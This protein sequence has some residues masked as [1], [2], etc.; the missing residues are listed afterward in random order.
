MMN[1][2]REL[3]P[4]RHTASRSNDGA[5]VQSHCMGRRLQWSSAFALAWL[6][7]SPACAKDEQ[8]PA[9]ASTAGTTSLLGTTVVTIRGG[10]ASWAGSRGLGGSG[11]VAGNPVEGPA[12][13][14]GLVNQPN[15]HCDDGNRVSGDGCTSECRL[16]ADHLC[17]VPG[18]PCTSTKVC[19]DGVL[20]GDESCDD[21]GTVEGDGCSATCVLEAGYQC[22]LPGAPCVEVCGDSKVV[23]RESC[24]DGGTE[25]GDGCSNGCQVEQDAATD[26][27]G[28]PSYWYCPTPGTPCVR[29]TCGNGLREGAERC[30]DG[31]G[32]PADGCSP[33]CQVEPQCT[34]V[35]C[36]SKCG[37]GIILPGES[38]E[39]DDGNA[40]DGDGCSIGCHVESGYHC[41]AV[42]GELPDRLFIPIVY[43]DFV[44]A[45]RAL[46]NA[47]VHPDFDSTRGAANGTKGLVQGTLNSV[48]VPVLT[49]FCVGVPVNGLLTGATDPACPTGTITDSSSTYGFNQMSGAAAFAQWYSDAPE[50]NRTIVSRLCLKRQ[51]ATNTYAFDS[52]AENAADC[53]AA[54]TCAEGQCWFLPINTQGFVAEG[55]EV[56]NL[57]RRDRIFGSADPP[58]LHGNFN[59]TSVVRTWFIYQGSEQLAFSGDDDVWVFINGR[60][61][62]DIGGLHGIVNGSVTL[63]QTRATALGL[64][65][66]HVYEIVLFHAERYGYG[67]N[68]KLTLTGFVTTKSNCSPFCGDGI[69]VGREACDHGTANVL[70]TSVESY[71]QCT[72]RCQLGPRCGDG[73]VQAEAGEECDA[74]SSLTIHTDTPGSGCTPNCKLPGY[75]GDGVLQVGYEACDDG[76]SN[77]ADPNGYGKCTSNCSLGPHCGDAIV[78]GPE[79]CDEGPNNGTHSCSIGCRLPVLL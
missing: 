21:G 79:Q 32:R 39:C 74:P 4:V 20:V 73:V 78:N 23:G 57:S 50:V 67:S 37:D 44:G 53:A 2:D 77:S 63:D 11:A 29:A 64:V 13:G 58:A 47:P 55:L 27:V 8:N 40:L 1:V 43:R 72:D 33:D 42:T 51:G 24:D 17:T 3:S 9:T 62:V 69:R 71:G 66:G 76:S 7:L 68:F 48:G 22:P 49:G 16:E 18:S 60:L 28:H 41:Q 45:Q 35:G 19:G 26:A 31:N 38:E 75:C 36:S 30:D 5:V 46:V 70:A 12:C 59:F 65:S 6:L 61:A 52:K 10:A 15:E 54:V 14:D 25:S 56:D 34:S